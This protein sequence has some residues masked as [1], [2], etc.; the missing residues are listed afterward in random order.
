[1]AEQNAPRRGFLH[2]LSRRLPDGGFRP[3]LK[4]FALM[5]LRRLQAVAEFETEAEAIAALEQ[6]ND[7]H[8]R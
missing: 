7:T 1:M 4:P 5:D 3:D 2:V 6:A 8:R